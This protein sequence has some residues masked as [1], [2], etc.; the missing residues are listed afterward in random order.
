M[1]KA[2]KITGIIFGVILAIATFGLLVGGISCVACINNNDVIKSLI[3]QGTASSVDN[4]KS[5]LQ[6]SGTT[7]IVLGVI[8]L[9]G[10]ALSFA[11]VHF[12][13]KENPSKASLIALGVLN[14]LFCNEVVGVLSIVHGAKNGN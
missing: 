10:C 5:L 2:L 4:A 14:I 8:F 13:K 1:Q 11:A 9:I 6:S 12:S 7:C 3:D